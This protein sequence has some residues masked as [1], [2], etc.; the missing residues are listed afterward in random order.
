[1]NETSFVYSDMRCRDGAGVFLLLE[2]GADPCHLE[3][4]HLPLKD[5]QLQPLLEPQVGNTVPP[6]SGRLCP[7]GTHYGA[8]GSRDQLLGVGGESAVPS[9]KV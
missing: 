5:S 1:M 4:D 3:G 9:L 8:A 6:D 7:S 2:R